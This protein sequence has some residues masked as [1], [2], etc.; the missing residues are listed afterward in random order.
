MKQPVSVS[1]HDVGQARRESDNAIVITV[2]SPDTK[3]P[4]IKLQVQ[5]AELAKFLSA[6]FVGHLNGQTLEGYLVT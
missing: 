6:K 3:I 5:R 2:S 1:I 4:F